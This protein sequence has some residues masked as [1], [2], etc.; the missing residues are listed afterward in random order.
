MRRYMMKIAEEFAKKDGC[1]GLIT[2]EAV[3]D[4]LVNEIFARFCMGK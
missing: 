1:L 2:G 4:D 3:D